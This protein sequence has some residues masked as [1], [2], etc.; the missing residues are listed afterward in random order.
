MLCLDIRKVH[1]LGLCDGL[2]RLPEHALL[3]QQ[4]AVGD[5]LLLVGPQL[6]HHIRNVLVVVQQQVL[7]PKR[8]SKLRL[9]G[10]RLHKMIFLR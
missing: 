3:E 9:A 1:E 6:V 2:V 7:V 5:L 10:Q 8:L 4:L